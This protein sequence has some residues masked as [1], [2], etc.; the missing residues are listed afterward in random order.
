MSFGLKFSVETFAG[1]SVSSLL[2]DEIVPMTAKR[3]KDRDKVFN[4]FMIHL[5]VG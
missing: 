1:K 3:I 2:Q 4:F 5:L